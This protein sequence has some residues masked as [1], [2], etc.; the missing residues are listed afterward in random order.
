HTLRVRLPAL[1]N[2]ET[3]WLPMITPASGGNQFYSLPDEGEQVACLLDARGENG[4]VLGATYNA[5]DTPPV[6]SKDMWVRRF[7]NGTVI[8]H[9]RENGQVT[10]D[11][12]G[13]VLIKAAKQVKI[14]TPYTEISGNTN[15][16]G[17]LTYSSG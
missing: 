10:V 8:K 2:M 16:L 7:K 4:V 1:E 6:A 13:D 3:D 9:N 17:H 11:T 12:P 14:N 15:I 5:A